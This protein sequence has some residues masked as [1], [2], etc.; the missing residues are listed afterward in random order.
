MVVRIGVN[1]R[2]WL[3]G[4]RSTRVG[5]TNETWDEMT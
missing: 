4:K 2:Y 1:R 5:T 3:N